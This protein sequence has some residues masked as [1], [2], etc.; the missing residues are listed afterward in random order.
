MSTVYA[1]NQVEGKSC[2]N[3]N[4]HWHFGFAF[5]R[6]NLKVCVQLSG[7]VPKQNVGLTLCPH[8][9]DRNHVARSGHTWPGTAC[10][11]AHIHGY[12]TASLYS[13][14]FCH[15]PS[16]LS[17]PV[18]P[19]PAPFAHFS[20]VVPFS[21]LFFPFQPCFCLWTGEK[22]IE[23]LKKWLD[24]TKLLETPHSWEPGQ[25]S[26]IAAAIL[27][28][29][30]LLPQQASKFLETQ[31]VSNNYSTALTAVHELCSSVDSVC[32]FK[33]LHGLRGYI[34]TSLHRGPGTA[35]ATLQFP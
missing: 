13:D 29:F 34:Q 2:I 25:E 9:S 24:T 18:L 6:G 3:S 31:G 10:T 19:F 21:A 4:H 7:C 12:N 33:K 30:H 16:A 5:G 11:I 17:S 27:E 23:H 22:L 32:M 35:D 1:R 26:D 8:Q 14:H 28:L 20:P 15:T